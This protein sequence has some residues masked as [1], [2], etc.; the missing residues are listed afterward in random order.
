MASTIS[1]SRTSLLIWS[2]SLACAAILMIFAVSMYPVPDGDSIG[3]VPAI[4]AYASTGQL[5]NKLYI[6]AHTI[7]PRG[8]GRF[9]SYT[10]G[11]TV[12]VGA[13]MRVL[14]QTGYPA[15]F[16]T[17]AAV[18]CASLFLF[19]QLVISSLGR[20]VTKGPWWLTAS[21]MVLIGS[22]A[23]FL[24]A[25][26]GR[27]EIVSMLLISLALLGALSLH[28]QVGRHVLIQVCIG[29]LFTT[30]IANALIATSMYAIYV[31]FDFRPTGL[32]VGCLVT[33]TVLACF[34]LVSCYA[35]VGVSIGDAI[36]GLAI[37]GK[38]AV[39]EFDANLSLAKSMSYYRTWVVFALLGAVRFTRRSITLWREPF[40]TMQD[41]GLLLASVVAMMG[42]GY[43]FGGRSASNH[44][45][46]Y[47]FLPLYQLLTLQLLL[48]VANQATRA[49]RLL[50]L[51][52]TALAAF[53]SLMQPIQA[54][55]LFP[56]YLTSGA[57]YSQAKEV[58][59]S[60]DRGACSVVYTTA[61]AWLDDRQ[62][63]SEYK[64]SENGG[65]QRTE[66]MKQEHA[67]K[68]CV[69]AFVQEVNN[70]SQPPLDMQQIADF[71]DRSTTTQRLRALRL[72]NSPKGYSF[73]AYQGA[74]A[75]SIR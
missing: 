3:F 28:S 67:D 10:P 43:Y 48:A 12:M 62:S 52:A 46:L 8:L 17:L 31:V 16:I 44:Y 14:G 73:R 9:L 65:I 26:N 59:T 70:H 36:S 15:A 35:L 53:L 74:S 7:D 24:F 19:T 54:A 55:L 58:Y 40:T 33:T 1:V 38:R 64:R 56:Y 34:F 39:L 68:P 2:L 30:S 37:S 41:R 22:N 4:T 69:M 50:V 13:V 20:R 27:P 61:I 49:P 29:L 25:S 5:E 75:T 32:R 51:S 6:R 57:T 23:L 42:L 72:L 63:G 11:M 71:G 21:A 45:T 47:A 66:R 60:L 18:R